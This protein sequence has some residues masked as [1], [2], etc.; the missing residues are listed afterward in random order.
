MLFY[1][2]ISIIG[3][4]ISLYSFFEI[5]VWG[6]L[7]FDRDYLCIEKYRKP[8]KLCDVMS[9]LHNAVV[10]YSGIVLLFAG[11]IM[12]LHKEAI[13]FRAWFI[14]AFLLFLVDFAALYFLGKHGDILSIKAAIKKQWDNQKKVSMENDH[15]VNM[16]RGAVRVCDTYPKQNFFY[17]TLLAV[18]FA[19]YCLVL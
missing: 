1:I 14:V 11:L 6:G 17:L 7:Y 3:L 8:Q 4:G 2:V 16:Y 10:S 15:E 19:A 13:Q 9:A 18:T 5:S 12:A